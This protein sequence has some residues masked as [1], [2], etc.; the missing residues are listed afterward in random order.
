M[1]SKKNFA[2]NSHS[3]LAESNCKSR[4]ASADV[5][6][7]GL[8]VGAPA[9]VPAGAECWVSMLIGSRLLGDAFEPKHTDAFEPKHTEAFEPTHTDAFEPT[10][11]DAFEP[12]HTE[13]TASPMFWLSSEMSPMFWLH[14]PSAE[15]VPFPVG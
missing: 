7:I 5:P 2:Q 15:V 6:S 3:S 13:T 9:L 12:K 14:W 1:L 4:A 8:L 11:R 10:H